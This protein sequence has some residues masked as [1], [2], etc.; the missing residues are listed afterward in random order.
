[1]Y[2]GGYRM[3]FNS[4]AF[5]FFLPV[6]FVI[7]WLIPKKYQWVLLLISSYYF[8][9][10]WS[11]KYVFLILITTGVSFLSGRLLGDARFIKYKK[12]VLFSS[13]FVCLGV[14]FIFKYYNFFISTFCDF[15]ELFSLHLHP[16]TLNLLLPVGISFY[17]FQTLSYVIDV[18]QCRV[19]P[20]KNF[21]KYAAFISFFP[22]LVAG[23]VERTENLLPQIKEEHVFQYENAVYGLR[24][25]LWGFFKKIVIADT[26]AYYVDLVYDDPFSYRGGGNA[27]CSNILLYSDIL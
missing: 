16:V 22:Q 24:Q 2:E 27:D 6:V 18:Y 4:I 13:V 5:A 19:Q 1:M 11:A 26:L 9:M 12:I 25:M 20:E 23:P 14:L 21:G 17:T 15:M 10:S 7:Y 3:S 8:Y